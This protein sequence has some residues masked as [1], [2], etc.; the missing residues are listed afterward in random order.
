MREHANEHEG[1]YDVH[2]GILITA[3]TTWHRKTKPTKLRIQPTYRYRIMP[4]LAKLEISGDDLN[5]KRGAPNGAWNAAEHV[6]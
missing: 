4:L 1:L 2:K 6:V 5:Y 3:E